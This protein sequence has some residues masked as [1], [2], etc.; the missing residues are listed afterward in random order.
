MEEMTA[1]HPWLPFG[2]IVRVENRDNGRSSRLRIND[3]GPF[4]RGRILDVSRAGA[5]ALGMLGPGTAR[6]RLVVVGL[7]EEPACVELQVGAFEDASNARALAE[8]L[9]ASGL[10][11]R[12]ERAPNGLRRVVAGP[13]GS[14]ESARAA[15]DRFGGYLRGC[16]A[17]DR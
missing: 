9:E 6:V 15:R 8:K 17:A 13:F 16:A 12:E 14:L 7:P 3:R 10:T 1:A 4:A 11:V 5:R 2:T